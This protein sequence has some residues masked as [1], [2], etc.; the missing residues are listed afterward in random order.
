M[1]TPRQLLCAFALAFA[2]LA[3]ADVPAPNNDCASKR[4]GDACTT[5]AKAAGACQSSTCSKLDYSDGSPPSTIQVPCLVCAAG[6]KPA[7]GCSAVPLAG[8]LGLA[9]AAAVLRRRRAAR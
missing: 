9:L 4:A 6:V 8:P 1:S 7:N 3:M 5:D 2:S